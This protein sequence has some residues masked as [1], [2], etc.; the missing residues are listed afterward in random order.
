MPPLTDER[1]R[2]N[3]IRQ[4]ILGFPRDTIAQHND[5]GAGTV[6]SIIANYKAGLEELDFDSIRQLAVEARQHGLNFADLASHARLYNYFVKSGASEDQ[7]ESFISNVSS[8]DIPPEQ[9]IE[10]VYQLHEIS[11]NESIPL[12]QVSGYIKQ[13]LEEKQKIDEQIKEADAILQS[14]NVSI[15][16]INEHLQLNEELKKYRLSTKDIHKL[17]NL[18]VAAKEYRYSPG[19][20]VAKL[21]NIKR[22]ENK[23]VKLKTSCEALSKKE[24]R[25]K[26]VI[27]F[28]EEI[29]AFGIGIQELIGLE[30]GIKEA[31]KMYNSS[32]FNSTLRLIDDIKSY[33]KINGLRRELDRLSLQ[34]YAL[35]QACSRQ[36]QSLLK[37][38]G[39]TEDRL[40]QLNNLLENNGYKDTRRNTY[41]D[42]K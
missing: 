13:K 6:S 28:T 42:I 20:I 39:V 24:A 31:A 34:K 1:T 19:K 38:Y 30:I 33:N 22:L 26:D 7:I 23:E 17:L 27:P 29:V 15:E 36:R 35:D 9:T 25:Y 41:V 37:S 2:I 5:I 18:L 3:V 21:R 11:N 10:L 32:F 4:W 40:V 12:D 8:S 14:K 16:A